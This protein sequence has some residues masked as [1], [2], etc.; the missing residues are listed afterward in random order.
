MTKEAGQIFV[1]SFL[2]MTIGFSAYMVSQLHAQELQTADFRN[3]TIAEVKNA[4]NEIVLRGQFEVVEDD[5]GETERQAILADSSGARKL[6]E[7][8][9][10]F[11]SS[12]Y[13]QEI[14][15]S[16]ENVEPGATFTFI[17]DG[18]DVGTARAN[19]DGKAEF[20]IEIGKPAAR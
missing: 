19:R 2:F 10:E 5:E 15:F 13:P 18:Q 16:I 11:P 7:A 1:A 12:G 20:E 3:A 6:G 9:V 4:Q 17:I 8:E 14:D